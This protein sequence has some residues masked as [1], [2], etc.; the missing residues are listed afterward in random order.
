MLFLN[1]YLALSNRYKV[2]TQVLFLC[3]FCFSM[4]NAQEMQ[5]YIFDS[6]ADDDIHGYIVPESQPAEQQ[7]RHCHCHDR[8][9][10]HE[11]LPSSS[12]H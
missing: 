11:S 1:V 5:H 4:V 12:R 8:P 9:N 7:N 6:G 10:T 2:A 3:L